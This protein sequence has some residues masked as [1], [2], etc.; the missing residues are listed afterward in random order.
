MSKPK[1]K[2]DLSTPYSRALR[3][4][5]E[6][7][8]IPQMELAE[9]LGMHRALLSDVELGKRR[10]VHV[11]R[12]QQLALSTGSDQIELMA[13]AAGERG[14]DAAMTAGASSEALEALIVLVLHLPKLTPDKAAKLRKY[15]TRL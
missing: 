12:T 13:L 14:I 8:G 1:Q 7:A 11:S 10:A 3:A 6:A 15:L 4:A 5:R 9:S 2:P